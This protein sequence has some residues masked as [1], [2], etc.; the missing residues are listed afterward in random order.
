MTN[1]TLS[2]PNYYHALMK[3]HKEIKWTEIMRNAAIMKLRELEDK[4]FK[5]EALNYAG[6]DW[7]EASELFKL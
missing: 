4:S 6:E 1:V 3:K 7:N 2:I 5:K